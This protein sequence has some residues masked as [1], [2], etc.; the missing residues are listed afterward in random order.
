MKWILA[1]E[2]LPEK[3]GWYFVIQQNPANTFKNVFHFDE[4]KVKANIPNYWNEIIEWLD[5]SAIPD[6]IIISEL[7]ELQKQFIQLSFENIKMSKTLCEISGYG[8]DSSVDKLCEKSLEAMDTY[9]QTSD[10]IKDEQFP[11]YLNSVAH[12]YSLENEGKLFRWYSK[13]DFIAGAKWQESK[14]QADLKTAVELAQFDSYKGGFRAGWSAGWSA[15][16]TKNTN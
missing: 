1:H 9:C 7:T 4:R 16:M 14:Q 10:K 11:Y 3:T 6:N 15:S 2:R 8:L 13:K 5:E 12:K